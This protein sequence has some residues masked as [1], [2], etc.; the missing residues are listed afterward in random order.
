MDIYQQRKKSHFDILFLN[1]SRLCYNKNMKQYPSIEKRTSSSQ[2]SYLF[3]KYD[4]SN[5]RCEWVKKHKKFVKFGSRTQLMDETHLTLGPSISLIKSYEEKFNEVFLKNRYEKVIC[6]FE[7]FG[8]NSFAGNHLDSDIKEVR[9]LDLS[10]HPKGIL[11]PKEFLKVSEGLPRAELLYE[12]FLNQEVVESIKNGSLSGMTFEGVIGKCN[13]G[14]PGL[15]DMFKIKNNAWL[16]KLKE[17][18]KGDEDLF[19]KLS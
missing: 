16:T 7:F 8:P 5:I 12:G 11:T 18:C 6:F 17:Y 19:N 1:L 14:T 3:D 9:L 15:P 4:G 13:S 2:Y 10:V